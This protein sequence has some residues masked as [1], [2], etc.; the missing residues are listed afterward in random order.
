MLLHLISYTCM[1]S[2]TAEKRFGHS[3]TDTML[4]VHNLLSPSLSLSQVETSFKAA[5]AEAY[6]R[7]RLVHASQPTESV[8]QICARHVE[9]V[10]LLLPLAVSNWN[11]CS[12]VTAT[13]SLL[14]SPQWRIS[15]AGT[16][17]ARTLPFREA[18]G[19]LVVGITASCVCATIV[20]HCVVLSAPS[21]S[22]V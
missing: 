15:A 14:F 22:P 7:R 12:M 11:A 9:Q 10:Q 16:L 1:C 17:V 21:G 18:N 5:T 4:Y 6:V 3:L 19:R 2:S 8:T 20:I 13:A